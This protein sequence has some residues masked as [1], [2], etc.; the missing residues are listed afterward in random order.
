MNN[1][2]LIIIAAFLFAVV[3]FSCNTNKENKNKAEFKQLTK[4]DIKNKKLKNYKFLN[5][6]RQD[7][8]FPGFLVD[9][10][11]RI[12]IELCLNI[13]EQKPKSLNELYK[14]THGA[15]NEINE[16]QDEFYKNDSEIETAARE[17]I[18]MDFYFIAQAY[19]FSAADVEE[20][21]ATR[22]W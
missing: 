7:K 18:A 3:L 16:L 21:I 11:E 20:L 12:L 13:E 15:T 8:Y 1:Q 5:G 19:S 2:V 17:I 9:K 6:M 22:D 10:C 4:Q 14:L